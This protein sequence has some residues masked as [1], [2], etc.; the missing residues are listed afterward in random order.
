MVELEPNTGVY[1]YP[2]HL[3]HILNMKA[4]ADPLSSGWGSRIARYLTGV[5]WSSSE[6]V[7]AT[8][9]RDPKPGQNQL[10]PLVI[11][12]IISK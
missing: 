7:N 4:K 10:S 3:T 2:H 1:I 11:D 8:I 12:A 9:S 5:F 6:L